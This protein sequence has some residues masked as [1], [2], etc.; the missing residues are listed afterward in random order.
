M[1]EHQQRADEN[2]ARERMREAPQPLIALLEG[3]RDKV[4]QDE[5]C[6]ARRIGFGLE[7]AGVLFRTAIELD[8]VALPDLL[9]DDRRNGRA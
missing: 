1:D 8:P 2:A 4:R 7:V 9:R 5:L 6:V 3:T